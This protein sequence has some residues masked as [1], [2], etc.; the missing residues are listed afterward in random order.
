MLADA[1]QN[2]VYPS[3]DVFSVFNNAYWGGHLQPQRGWDRYPVRQEALH[4]GWIQGSSYEHAVLRNVLGAKGAYSTVSLLQTASRRH[5]ADPDQVPDIVVLSQAPNDRG[6]TWQQ[7]GEIVYQA[8]KL[9]DWR[10]GL[11][12]YVIEMG[13]SS[14]AA[15]ELCYMPPGPV[16]IDG[17]GRFGVAFEPPPFRMSRALVIRYPEPP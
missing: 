10:P 1:Q 11:W 4:V 15:A 14:D 3:M 7:E 6:K 8:K 5:R 2:L 17:S 9:K 13:E 12:K 16:T